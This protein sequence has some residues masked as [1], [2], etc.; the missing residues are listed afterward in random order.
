MDVRYA[1]LSSFCS[2]AHWIW[3]IFWFSFNVVVYLLVVYALQDIKSGK[4]SHNRNYLLPALI[5][6]I[7]NVVA[8]V[9]D[10]IVNFVIFN[11]F[12]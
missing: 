5:M 8:G 6:S 4:L 9:I 1:G 11:W 3:A 10:V 2:A 12:G 7:I